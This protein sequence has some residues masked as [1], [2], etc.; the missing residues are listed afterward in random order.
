MIQRSITPL[1]QAALKDSP[2]VLLNG[3]RQ[4]GK[5][6]LVEWLS[7][8]GHSARYVTLDD[9]VVLS[10][11]HNSPEGFLAGYNEPLVIDEIQRAPELFLALKA[12]IDKKRKAGQFLLTGSANVLL[13]PKL[14][15]S[16]AGRMEIL[17]LY[18]FS[19]SEI[20]NTEGLFIDE[21]FDGKIIKYTSKNNKQVHLIERMMKGGYYEAFQREDSTRRNAWFS[22]YITTILQRDVR[23]LAH[24]EGLTALPR[25]L[26][27]L[28]SRSATLLNFAELSNSIKIPQTTLKRYCAL[29][30]TTFLSQL[31]PSW[32]RNLSKRLIKTP[33]LYL[34]DTGLMLYLLG[35]D[36][37]RLKA[38]GDIFGKAVESFVLNELLKLATWSKTQPRIYHFRTQ[39]G[40]EIDFLLERRDGSIVCLEVK[41][42]QK[43]DASA[44]KTMKILAGE[45]K[46]K[47]LRGIVLYD[48]NEVIPF[49]KNLFAVPMQA[50]WA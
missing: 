24:I 13:I 42:G 26:A 16:L 35:A 19:Q 14:S 47:F 49:E 44:F 4:V 50:L 45:L 43:V 32:S 12:S 6:T 18:P 28:A 17:S 34:T 3:A 10:A 38:D 15:E 33:K 27:L 5:S 31:I 41:S 9:A 2:V 46:K 21:L 11:A 36:E 8:N 1:L 22:S 20:G 30:E 40:M 39:T 29:L 7:S 25:L 48:G 37:Q 23:D